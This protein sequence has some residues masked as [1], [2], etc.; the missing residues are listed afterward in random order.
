MKTKSYVRLFDFSTPRSAHYSSIIAC[1]A[2]RTDLYGIR[3]P[4]SQ[5]YLTE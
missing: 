1:L 2:P 5:M 4:F 3:P